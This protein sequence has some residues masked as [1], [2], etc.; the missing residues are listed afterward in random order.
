MRRKLLLLCTLYLASNFAIAQNKFE[1]VLNSRKLGVSYKSVKSKAKE[2]YYQQYFW[3]T[4]T[5][6]LTKFPHLDGIKPRVLYSFVKEIYPQIPTKSLTEENKKY[7]ADAE[8]SLD[9]YFKNKDWTNPVLALNLDTY[10]DPQNEKYHAHVKPES[11]KTLIPK[12]LYAFTSDNT[13]TSERKLQY[14]WVHDNEYKIVNIIPDEKKNPVFYEELKTILPGYTFPDFYPE[15]ASMGDKKVPSDVNYHY[16]TAF[17]VGNNNI[18]YKTENFED[19]IF[20]RY[21]KD[22]G[23]WTDVEHREKKY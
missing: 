22:G 13:Q 4:K 9:Q 21:K 15:S 10:V 16:I 2:D 6:E 14:L 19:F 11:I 3:L 23:P 17:Q 20:V 7:R 8:L 1:S 18:V 12:R 5:E